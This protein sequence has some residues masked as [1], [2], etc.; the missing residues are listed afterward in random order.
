MLRTGYLRVTAQSSGAL[1]C[2]EYSEDTGHLRILKDEVLVRE[3]FPPN[4]WLAIAS[5][6][7]ARSW[8]TGPNANELRALLESQMSLR[9][10]TS[11]RE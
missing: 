8:G 4:S 5:V 6:V 1:M 9:V 7:G 2:A 11:H 3:W 10:S